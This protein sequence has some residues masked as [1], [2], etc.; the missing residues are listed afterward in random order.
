MASISVIG[1][2][3]VGLVS[4]TMFAD[5]GHH[6]YC[7][8]N[9]SAKIASIENGIM[10]I[11][12]P[13]LKELV[14]K[15]KTAGR[16][17]F[18]TSVKD[19]VNSSD[20]I[21]IAV[22]TPM[23][24]NHLADLTAVYA[25]AKEIGEHIDGYKVI[26]DKS[27]VPVGTASKVSEIIG[28]EIEKR[29]MQFEFEVVSNPEFL[30][31]GSALYDFANPDRIVVG[32]RSDK[33]LS[34]MRE[35]YA[36]LTAN[37]IELVVTTP[38]SAE[39][40]KYA[41]NAF[42]AVK[43]SFINEIS[44][45]CEA[46]GANVLDVSRAMGL[47]SRISAQFLQAGPGYGGSCFPKDTR[48]ICATANQHGLSLQVIDSA[49]R[50]NERQKEHMAQKIIKEFEDMDGVRLTFLGVTF[51]PS[52][53]DMRDAPALAIIP[54]LVQLGAQVNIYDPKG[55]EQAKECFREFQ[56][57]IN[58]LSDPYLAAKDADAAIL[59]THWQEFV[60]LDMQKLKQ[61]MKGNLFFDL[62]NMF[63]REAL[64]KSGFSYIGVGR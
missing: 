43:I 15:N 60:A 31:E 13:G 45:L 17:S 44:N 11:Y 35:V 54:K 61:Q 28:N 64:E 47:D 9:D 59:L 37:G 36:P 18:C 48:A 52:T 25:V 30:R 3:Y 8:D 22:G 53:D 33:A 41:C 10:P 6:V 23:G 55:M 34:L 42:L 24:E 57:S 20:I 51:K 19:A 21:F 14:T 27:T 16:L 4:G 38:E 5:I 7:C 58:Y 1:T 63:E 12:E 2:G 40:I 62:R 50:A 49:I 29:G 46:T 56:N 39:M 26:V 32:V